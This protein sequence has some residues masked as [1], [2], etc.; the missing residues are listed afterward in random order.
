MCFFSILI[1]LSEKFFA[2]ITLIKSS[3]GNFTPIL[4]VLLTLDRK[5]GNLKLY[6]FNI[7]YL[8]ISFIYI[9]HD[10]A[11]AKY[12]ADKIINLYAGEI[13]ESGQTR[14]ILTNPKHPYTKAL[15]DAISIPDPKNI[16]KEKTIGW[17]TDT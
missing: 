6:E 15:I 9:T 17:Q 1:C 10:L 3:L 8:Y 7:F 11:T 16:Y 2:R 12:F 4:S 14:D 13:M 5:S